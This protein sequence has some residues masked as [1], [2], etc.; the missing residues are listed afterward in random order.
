MNYTGL[1]FLCL[2]LRTAQLLM[3]ASKERLLRKLEENR[4]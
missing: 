1:I 2:S 4:E 3:G